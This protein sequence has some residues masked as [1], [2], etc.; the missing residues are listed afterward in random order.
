MV[1]L[2]FG[3]PRGTVDENEEFW[4]IYIFVPWGMRKVNI[5]RTQGS[6]LQTLIVSVPNKFVDLP[7]YLQLKTWQWYIVGKKMC[8]IHNFLKSSKNC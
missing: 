3:Q 7:S 4:G 6:P 8:N 1:S 2:H 5:M